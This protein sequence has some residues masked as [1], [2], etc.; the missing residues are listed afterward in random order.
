MCGIKPIIV[1]LLSVYKNDTLLQLQET[2]TSL[3]E[4]SCHQFD[5]YVMQDGPVVPDVDLYLTDLVTSR[6][7]QYLGKRAANKGLAFT[8]N[9]LL[10]LAL[11]AGYEY[12]ARMDADDVCVVDRIEAQFGFMER[13][14]EVDV[15]GG[16]IEEFN[17]DTG[18]ITLVKY[19]EHHGEVL[20][21]FRKRCP[22][23]HVT[24]FF[25]R[26]F[27]IKAGY[28]RTDTIMNEDLALWIE[29]FKNGCCFHNL[30][31][32]VVRVRVNNAFYG[33]RSGLAK[34]WDDVRWKLRAK[35][36]LALGPLTD[37]YALGTFLI[38]QLPPRLKRFLYG[39]LR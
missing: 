17:V 30:Q 2:M 28:Y 24:T 36:E 8:L 21:F 38:M 37:A 6:Q 22:M 7:I 1:V 16:W 9:E 12:I 19:P 15:V 13:H 3:F 23:A 32:I 14:P 4:Q 29:G 39:T 27:F 33:R 34:A 5:I 11:A 20:M 26:T 10:R 35:R 18:G 31:T 25:R